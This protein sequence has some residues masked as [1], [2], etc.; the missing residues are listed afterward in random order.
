MKHCGECGTGLNDGL[1]EYS[2]PHQF[3][4]ACGWRW[5]SPPIP[6]V[7]VLVTTSDGEIVYCRKDRQPPGIWSVVSG[8]I[9]RGEPAE[10]TA[11]REV[12]EETNLDVEIV[13]S[14]GTHVF[15]VLPDQLVIAYH[16]RVLSGE[17]R[18]GDDVDHVEVAPPD[19]TR[20]FPGSTS[21]HLVQQYIE[22]CC[23]R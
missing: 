10:L 15:P 6:V 18:A 7:L 5:Y 2:T 21:L 9:P 23:S 4:E 16:A 11:V 20:L 17:P 12:K 22:G 19:V 14:A 1:D 3:C 13:H 8:F